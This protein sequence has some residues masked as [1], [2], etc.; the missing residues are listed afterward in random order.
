MASNSTNESQHFSSNTKDEYLC[1]TQKS[2]VKICKVT[3]CQWWAEK[4]PHKCCH[5]SQKNLSEL[6]KLKGITYKVLVEKSK[7]G[8]QDIERAIILDRLLAFAEEVNITLTPKQE[9]KLRTIL[10]K[11]P[12]K[13]LDVR[14]E[15]FLGAIKSFNTFQKHYKIN[16]PVNIFCISDKTYNSILDMITRKIKG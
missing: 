4:A 12:Y 8:K 13:F 16:A 10:N 9:Q 7:K 14:P 2:P 1:P 15:N 6:A 3:S 5:S 11:E